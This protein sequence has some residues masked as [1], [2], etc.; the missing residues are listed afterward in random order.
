MQLE[1][2]AQRKLLAVALLGISLFSSGCA[3]M[4]E[5]MLW[6]PVDSAVDN[7]DYKTRVDDYKSRGVSQKNAERAAYEDQ[8]FDKM[9]KDP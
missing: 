9:Q 1:R 3:S 2:K 6:S 7:Y 8:F 4:V 5:S